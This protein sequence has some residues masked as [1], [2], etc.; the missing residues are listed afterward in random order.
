M[1]RN[2]FFF[3][4]MAVL[5]TE[6][7]KKQENKCATEDSEHSRCRSWKRCSRYVTGT[8]EVKTGVAESPAHFDARAEVK[9]V[10]LQ[11]VSGQGCVVCLLRENARAR[12][13]VSYSATRSWVRL[14]SQP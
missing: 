1:P 14:S 2:G 9:D 3:L 13:A 6:T 4:F 8:P 12:E 10:G 7:E 11:S 5:L